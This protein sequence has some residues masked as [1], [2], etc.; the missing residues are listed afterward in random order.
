MTYMMVNVRGQAEASLGTLQDRSCYTA[1]RGFL[2]QCESG[3]SLSS[4]IT[5]MV[6]VKH[7]A[8]SNLVF[9]VQL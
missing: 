2:G 4:Y 8:M 1:F 9:S 7:V 6:Q 3:T 5:R